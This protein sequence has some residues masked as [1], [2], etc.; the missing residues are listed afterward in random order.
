MKIGFIGAGKMGFTLGKHLT[1]YEKT[2]TDAGFRVMGYYS[3]NPDSAMEAARFTDTNYYENTEKLIEVCDAIFLTV[4]DGQ[5]QTVCDRL[6][7]STTAL[8]GKALIHTSGALSSRVFSGMGDR[9]SGYSL[10]PIYAV[11]SK[12]DSYLH[13]QDCFMT[14][15]GTGAYTE[16]LITLFQTLGHTVKRISEE[17]KAKYHASAVFASNLVIGLYAMGTDLLT[18]CGFSP[19]EAECALLPLF[20]NN[21]DNIKRVGMQKALTGPV[22]RC[23]IKTVE[24]HL[25]TLD[26]DAETVYRCLSKRLIPLACSDE[27]MDEGYISLLQILQG[28]RTK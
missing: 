7:Q 17:H 10:H 24:Q 23:D 16:P 18:D 1:E 9:V 2:H 13:F 26:G 8:T 27:A 25:N 28:D 15:E 19:E 20:A 12:T 14:I 4:P 5:I 21:A 6:A 11:N 22:S 3:Q